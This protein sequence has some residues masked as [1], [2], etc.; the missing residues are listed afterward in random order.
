MWESAGLF[1]GALL[2]ALIGPNL[3]V[4][5]EPFLIAA[6]YQLYQGVWLGVIA[7]LC[8]ALVGDQASY[9]IGRKVG[10]SA[11]RKL[12]RFQPKIRR[13]IA[14]CRILMQKRGNYVL[15]F[16]RL[17]GPVSWVVPFM[18]GTQN[19]EWRR[20][21]LFDTF[22]VMLGV[23]QFVFWGYLL[24]AGIEQVP[25]VDAAKTFVLEHQYLLVLFACTAVVAFIAY[26]KNWRFPVTKSIGF[27][28]IGMLGVNYSHFFWFSDDAVV[29][30]G[31]TQ[32]MEVVSQYKENANPSLISLKTAFPVASVTFSDDLM[33]TPLLASDFKVYPGKSPFF[34]AQA[35]NLVLIGESPRTLMAQL[36]WIENKTFSRDEI[37]WKDYLQ[38]LSDKTPPVSD[39]FWNEEP[40]HMAFQ[41]PGTLM[42]R[43]HV[44][45]WKAGVD[46]ISQQ[47]RW[48]G[49]ISYDD[50][51]ILTPYS[52]IVTVLH[53]IDPNVDHERD[54]FAAKVELTNLN[55]STEMQALGQITVLDDQ[56][57][58]YSDGQVL[59]IKENTLLAKV[60]K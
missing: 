41:L 21:S 23:G 20:F 42:K 47:P 60:T 30:P 6:G 14:R 36:G 33:S 53:S 3:F 50:G 8:G 52:G 48:V 22:G 12:M 39:L 43:S 38:L 18:A 26:K 29:T 27:L 31:N 56:H 54:Q 58:Y 46:P 25:F 55:W 34:D 40:Q 5:G 10:N 57:D 16:S 11:Q 7:V 2:D 13:P 45:W 24:G 4:P 19:I 9:W 28:L 17:L 32:T 59:V 35:L 51:L 49:A 37:E 1:L 44:R 15:A